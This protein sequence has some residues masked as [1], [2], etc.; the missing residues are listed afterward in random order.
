MKNY[1]NPI[2]KKMLGCIVS[3]M[4]VVGMLPANAIATETTEAG[5]FILVVEA[6]GK[7]VIA[8]EYITYEEDQTIG[9]ALSNSE[10]VFTGLGSGMITEIDGEVGNYVRSDENG[11]YDLFKSA[12]EIGFF[13]FSEDEENSIPSEGMQKLMTSMAEY[14]K[15]DA[16][17]K[18]AAK[19]AYDDAY[20]Q[21]VGIDSYSAMVLADKLDEAVSRYEEAQNSEK[22]PV[23]F[24]NG[25]DKH[26]DSDITVKNVYGKTWENDG[27]GVIE[28]PEGEYSFKISRDGLYVE[29]NIAVDGAET[30]KAS[31]PEQMWLKR[32]TF[33]LSGSYG[34][35]DDEENKFTDDEYTVGEWNDRSVDVAVSD[36]F[37]GSIYTYAE[38]DES[39]VSGDTVLTA[40]YTYAKTGETEI[41]ELPF[42]SLTSGIS[43]VLKKGAEGNTVTYR[44]SNESEDGYTYSQDYTVNFERIPTLKSISVK[45]QEGVDQ[46]ATMAF[47]PI[48]TGYTY[49]IIDTV[50]K[51]NIKAEPLDE[52]YTA[53]IGDKNAAEGV[54]VQLS[55]GS[56]TTI[57]ITVN[58]GDY[59]NT[60]NLIIRPAEGKKL[61][62]VTDRS[63]VTL[64]VVNSNG[65]VMPYA[66]FREGD[67]GNR[68]QYTLV[69][70]ETYSYVATAKTYY[71]IADEFTMEDV[72]DSTINVDV[73]E[74][75]WLTD[76]AF[77]TS[78]AGS[79]KGS[80][81][82]D[83]TFASS[84]HN[85]KVK[86]IDTEHNAYVWVTADDSVTIRAIYKQKHS[87]TLYHGKEKTIS[88]TSGSTAGV[89]LNRLL[90]DE[91]PVENTVTIRLSKDVG[92][93]TC[94]QDY[95]VDFQ[96]I[97]SLKEISA[98]CDGLT[99][100]MIQED[101]TEGYKP[102]VTE[103]SVTVSM[104]AKSLELTL[105]SN[106]GNYCYGE[107]KIGYIVKVNGEDVPETGTA[108]ILLN[109]TLD[110]QDVTIT[111]E[112]DKAPEGTTNYLIH[113]LKSPP[114]DVDFNIAPENALMAMYETMSGERLWPMEDGK[115]R[116][117][118]GYSYNYTLT[119]YGHV[120]KTGTLEVTRDD[121]KNL[122]VNDG[123]ASYKVTENSNGGGALTVDWILA[124]AAD[125]T[126]IRTDMESEWSNF[127]GSDSN[128]SVTDAAI[129]T[130]AENGT[131][132]WANKIGNGYSAD[133]VGSPIL[134]DGDLITYAGANIFRV[135]T[136]TGEIKATGYMDHKSAHA[137]T[138][139]SYAEGMVFVALTD[140][141]VQAFNAETLESL[142]V[143]K[144]P[145]GGQPVCP[146]TIKDGFLY[147]GFW[148]SEKGDAN[149]VCLSITDEDPQ[150]INER[151]NA[152]WYHTTNGGYY[153]AGA[154]VS[155]NFVLIGTDDGDAGCTEP[156]S[157]MLMFDPVTGKLL[158]IWNNLDGDIRS[159]VVYDEAT[160]AYYFT[161]KG[162]S[163]YSLKVKETDAGWKMT[164]KWSIE[165]DNG[166]DGT[167]MS[168][169][170]PTVYNGRAY[171][172]VSG[173]GQFS[174]YSGHNISVIDLSQQKVAYKVQTQGY[175]QT[176]GL[177]TTAYEKESGY[178]YVYFFD[179]MTPGKLRVLRDK[180]G[181]TKADYVTTEGSHSAAYA[182][183]TPT[184]D[185][186]QYAI[187]SPIVDEYGTIYFKN[188]SAHM[189]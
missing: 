54:T 183:F 71:H 33:R 125:N 2:M 118:E 170:S 21:F 39:A 86:L 25:V 47:D 5:S 132:Y 15:K 140:G 112:N 146:L 136:I 179:N 1:R 177:L 12:S 109:G 123:D 34:D 94:Y 23:T 7:L 53:K 116:L 169:C 155:E 66:K 153:W 189:M 114:V 4:L 163:F 70:G 69:P 124:K 72:A 46:A 157:Q 60:Y 100:T 102:E 91:N 107:D 82:L 137:T 97:L 45:D 145:L 62:F 156:T 138:P 77:G 78:R 172:G 14:Q 55:A 181:Q 104:A 117:C 131:L 119:A 173:A 11:E 56:E 180:A 186:A 10:H 74:E 182:L 96:R 152:S 159:T 52:S 171:V 122:V 133:A 148:N 162:G 113:I 98:K 188:D 9:E 8:P 178:V 90:M 147:T 79:K 30:I 68:Y 76:M 174:A 154:Y 41:E 43:G 160:D 35:E 88:L 184:G 166:T 80:L 164:D 151:K 19:A 28:L 128:N 106:E 143:Y 49:K 20:S 40:I 6:Q 37:T 64:E 176:S 63:D 150:Q 87:S 158:D 110:T 22:Y 185:Q 129:P 84:D 17:V 29:G 144:D 57:P 135:D 27:D 38:Y 92:G 61:N 120:S 50:T 31:L 141:T 167:P 26:K 32:D 103:Y 59:S 85:Y 111:V 161:S 95:T 48:T 16:D 127:R 51:L 134:V 108:S 73:P 165:L 121:N 149:F 42:E 93:V 65:Q 139:P 187:C 36:I 105:V 75:D 67:S 130:S 13:R 115:F 44:I 101:E 168:T 18:A 89:Q 83:S 175:P 3:I 81:P 126:S 24:S 58:G 142:W 99:A